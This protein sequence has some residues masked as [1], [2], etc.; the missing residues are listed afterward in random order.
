MRLSISIT[1]Y[2]RPGILETAAAAAD[3]AGLDTVWVQDHLM[4][5]APG[6]DPASPMFEAYTAL[7]FL[8]SRT[9]RVRL[10]ALVSPVAY[11]PAAVLVKAVTTLD[12]LSGGRAWLGVGA[13]YLQADADAF[14]VP[15]PPMA[16]RFDALEATL[17]TAL[18][19]WDD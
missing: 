15:L 12:V 13:G 11:R 4:Q 6:S 2:S 14:D 19:M 1:D 16:A 17:R 10:G 7:G 3:E 5:R 18:R 8:A 9:C